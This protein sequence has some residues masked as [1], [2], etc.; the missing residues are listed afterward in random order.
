[1][2][3]WPGRYLLIKFLE[4]A[5]QNIARAGVARLRASVP[6]PF[7]AG[8]GRA[9]ATPLLVSTLPSQQQHAARWAVGQ[10]GRRTIICRTCS[11]MAGA[12]WHSLLGAL[13][14]IFRKLLHINQPWDNSCSVTPPPFKVARRLILFNSIRAALLL[15]PRASHKI[16]VAVECRVRVHWTFRCA[17][18]AA[19]D[20]TGLDS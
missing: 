12:I 6:V 14:S 10:V 15:L 17:P 16:V 1:M 3:A 4:S 11:S 7:Q 9:S 20:L 5:R 8:Q 19:I 2:Q 18:V 13:D